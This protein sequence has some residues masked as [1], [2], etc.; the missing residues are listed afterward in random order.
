MEQAKQ[1]RTA[2]QIAQRNNSFRATMIPAPWAKLVFSEVVANSSP[3]K[4]EAILTAVREFVFKPEDVGNNPHGECDFGKVTV[5][6]EDYFFKFDYYAPDMMYGADPYTDQV[7]IH[8]LTIMHAG[9][10]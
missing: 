6:D 10:Y 7:V 8:V 2:A 1:I 5:A 3:E 9:E 4:R